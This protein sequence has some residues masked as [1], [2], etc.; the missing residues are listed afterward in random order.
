[1]AKFGF[2][3]LQSFKDYVGFAKLCLPDRFPHRDGVE[4]DEQWS[5]NLAFEGLRLGLTM[6]VQEK[7]ER[8]E[9]VEFAV[10]SRRLTTH[11]TPAIFAQGS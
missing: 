2:N 4:A 10:W 5:F 11:T 3:D 8:V 9:F 1:M 6:A 7:G